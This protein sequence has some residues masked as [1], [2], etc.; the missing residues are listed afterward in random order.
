VLLLHGQPGSH[1]DWGGVIAALGDRARPISID[2]PGWAGD[3]RPADLYGNAAAAIAALDGLAVRR[4]VLAGHSFGAAIAA[5]VAVLHPERVAAL[6]LASPAANAASLDAVD[7]LLGAPLVGPVTSAATMAGLG[8]TL[9]LA[10]TG[11]VVARRLGLDRRYVMSGGRSLL[12]PRSWRAFLVEQRALLAQLPELE[13]RLTELAVPTTV[14]SGAA[15]RIV[16]LAA[17]TALAAQIPGARLQ[18]LPGAGHLLP[19]QHAERLADAIA[20]AVQESA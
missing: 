17:A 10:P 5:L 1:R 16:P 19:Q 15:D 6:V 8:L 2:R 13:R 12:S 20:A 4:A 7:R 11:G 14:V 9:A 3:T 18:T